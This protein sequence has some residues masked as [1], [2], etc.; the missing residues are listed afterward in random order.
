MSMRLLPK[1]A[2]NKA[3]ALDR[4]REID[5]GKKLATRV[6]KLREL[7]A[8][9]EKNLMAFREKTMEAIQA[10]IRP[11]IDKRDTLL[12]DI[13]DRTTQRNILL[14]PL[15]AKWE[16]VNKAQALCNDWHKELDT[17]Q[18]EVATSREG[19][20]REAKELEV[21]RVSI[22]N[23]EERV[24]ELIFQALN[25]EEEA[26]EV[27]ARARNDAN[28]IQLNASIREIELKQREVALS[29]K[30]VDVKNSNEYNIS[31][32]NDNVAE[33]IRLA[34]MRATLERAIKRNKK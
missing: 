1:S 16:E 27:L 18:S 30:E 9:E 24:K 28:V 11:L 31:V 29:Y 8:I 19:L 10:E 21:K 2:I 20:F 33:S 5:E 14:I 13:K 3:K 32:H 23:N 7:S 26:K 22:S 34:D 17:R 4:Q 6:D 12:K 15:D 25:M